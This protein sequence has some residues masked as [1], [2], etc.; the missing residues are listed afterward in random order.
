[1]NALK[2]KKIMYIPINIK[3]FYFR[4]VIRLPAMFKFFQSYLE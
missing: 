2:S 1:M 3:G 4:E